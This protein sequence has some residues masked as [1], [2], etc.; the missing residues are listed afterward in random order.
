[1]IPL[2][3]YNDPKGAKMATTTRGRKPSDA[4]ANVNIAKLAQVMKKN[5]G[6]SERFYSEQSG[7]P[8]NLIG[9]AVYEAELVNDPSLK[10]AATGAQIAKARDQQK[11]RWGRIAVRAGITEGQ[12]KQLYADHTGT[13]P[14]TTYTGRGRNFANGGGTTASSGKKGSATPARGR[15]TS[16]RRAAAKGGAAASTGRGRARTRAERAGKDPS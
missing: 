3:Q 1:M 2:G 9:K 14:A 10:I 7:I 4:R 13:D 12:V 5:P 15:G 11:L 8:M 6:K 16:G